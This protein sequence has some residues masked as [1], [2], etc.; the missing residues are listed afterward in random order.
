MT[1]PWDARNKGC[2]ILHLSVG[3][4]PFGSDGNDRRFTKNEQAIS[5]PQTKRVHSVTCAPGGGAMFREQF[6]R[7]LGLPK[8]ALRRERRLTIDEL[9]PLAEAIVNYGLAI[10]A[11]ERWS[12]NPPPYTIVELPEL[13]LRFG[14]TRQAINDTLLLLS[15]M[16]CAEPLDRHGHWKLSPTGPPSNHVDER[17]A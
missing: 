13:E 9:L 6:L 1:I 11:H 10:Q 3:V 12:G 16:G 4:F 2:T 15:A 8:R 5:F 14:K 7:V 17:A